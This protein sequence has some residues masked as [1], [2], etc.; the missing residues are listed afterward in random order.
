MIRIITA[1]AVAAALV[2][3][4]AAAQSVKVAV[5]GRS[6]DQ[7]S[8]DVTTAARKVCRAAI[9]GATFPHEM[10]DAC[11]K[12]TLKNAQAQLAETNIKLAQR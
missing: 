11:I 9:V 10:Y 6:A 7:V 1:A 2:A 5:A 8:A 4:P 12:A 3:G